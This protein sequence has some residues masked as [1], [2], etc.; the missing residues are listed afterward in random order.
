MLRDYVSLTGPK[1]LGDRLLEAGLITRTQ[2]DIALDR[3]AAAGFRQRLG[4]ILVDLGFVTEGALTEMLSIHL[5]IPVAS[6]SVDDAER[7][8]LAL[9]PASLARRHRM[10]PCRVLDECLMVAIADEVPAEVVARVEALSG[11][12]V[13]PYL[14]SE[15]EIDAALQK[16]YGPESI[17]VAR[18]R[19]LVEGLDRLAVHRERLAR[20]LDAADGETGTPGEAAVRADLEPLR[21]DIAAVSRACEEASTACAKIATRVARWVYEKYTPQ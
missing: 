18:L 19:E 3:Q 10:L 9:V 15:V 8:A 5:G 14:A 1:S 20:V 6:F 12:R 2:L 11:R 17:V 7:S 4:R 13:V 16:R 21:R